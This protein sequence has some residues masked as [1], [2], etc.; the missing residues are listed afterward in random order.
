MKK[1]L[2]SLAVRD[3]TRRGTEVGRGVGVAGIVYVHVAG[4]DWTVR[5]T[6]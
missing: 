1:R 4:R 2:S 6:G 5:W 3:W